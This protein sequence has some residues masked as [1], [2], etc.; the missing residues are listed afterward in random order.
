MA[1]VASMK[2]EIIY[3]DECPNVEVAG[4]RVLEAAER[5]GV[6][7][8]VTRRLVVDEAEASAAGMCGSP[9]VLVAGVDVVGGH[10]GGSLSCRLYLGN[11]GHDG[12]PTIAAIT[13][14]LAGRHRREPSRKA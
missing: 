10:E 14:A 9:T 6:A 1:T 11:D 2:V 5:A 13:T 3:V 4:N 7:V 8:E 12:A